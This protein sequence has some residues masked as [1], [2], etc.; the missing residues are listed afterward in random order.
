LRRQIRKLG[1][2]PMHTMPT[3]NG[4]QHEHTAVKS[5][6][7]LQREGVPYEM[8]RTVCQACKRLLDE[9]RVRRANA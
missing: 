9:R 7:V 8:E 3:P 1:F 4:K 5:V 2:L 6:V